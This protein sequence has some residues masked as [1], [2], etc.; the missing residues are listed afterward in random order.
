MIKE[1]Q[2]NKY[3]QIGLTAFLVIAASILLGF[4]LYNMGSI[5]DIIKNFFL[6]FS[7]FIL[8]FVLAYLLNPI[9]EF[10]KKKVV[11]KWIKSGDK[12]TITY[13]SI[14]ITFV[15]FI[16]IIV[17]LFSIIIPELLKSIEKLAINLPMY[18]DEIKNFLLTKLGDSESKEIV[19]NNYETINEYLNT[20]VNNTLIPQ[21]DSWL[22]ALSNG[23]IG[24][25]K[26]I[27]NILLGFVIAI[28]FLADKDN[29]IGGIKKL[30]YLILPT[31]TA[32]HLMANARR[33]DGI[34]GG[35][36]V[37]RLLDGLVI[38]II[39]FLFLAI[40]GYPYALLIAVLVG[41]TNTIPYFGPWIGG[42]PS[43]LLILMDNPT[44][45]LIFGIFIV[46]L[47]Q[48]DGNVIGPRLCGDR[49]GLKSFWVLAAILLF[50][51]MFG[52][53]GMLVGVPIFALIYGY[54]TNVIARA[55][56]HQKM[57]EANEEYLYLKKIDTKTNEFIK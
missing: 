49:I 47:Q 35:F 22:L 16:L 48:I 30:T 20:V 54:L 24:I 50:G 41:L 27:F 33:T 40:F 13:L 52:L 29:F 31:R 28:Y 19:M 46:V 37:G 43:V 12:K 42:I 17:L 45:A 36:I 38:G 34:F 56:K 23:V 6:L 51:N 1:L 57:P 26:T 39:T 14:T 9:V 55:L 3:F 10:F 5:W 7:P 44:K 18:I 4:L 2:K 11:N 53:I 15:L 8:G 25:F 32:N 21:I